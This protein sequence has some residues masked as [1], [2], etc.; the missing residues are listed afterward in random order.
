MWTTYQNYTNVI[1]R[2]ITAAILSITKHKKNVVVFLDSCRHHQYSI[3]QYMTL[4]QDDA[5]VTPAD[6]FDGWIERYFTGRH[7]KSSGHHSEFAL[8]DT[9]I[10]HQAHDFPCAHCCSGHRAKMP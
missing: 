2:K 7:K 6:V 5:M 9:F 10:F 3:G 4:I 1:G 8:N